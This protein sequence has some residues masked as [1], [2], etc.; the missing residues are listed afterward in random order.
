MFEAVGSGVL[1]LSNVV[2][3]ASSSASGTGTVRFAGGASRVVAGAAYAAGITE[4]GS[5]GVLDFDDDGSTGALR[6]GL[7]DAPG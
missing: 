2:M 7:G 3:G 5:G 4:F 1:S 6:Y